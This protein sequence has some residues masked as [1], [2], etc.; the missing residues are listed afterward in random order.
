MMDIVRPK[1]LTCLG[2]WERVGDPGD[3]ARGSHCVREGS[4]FGGR[5]SWE[6]FPFCGGSHSRRTSKR[7]PFGGDPLGRASHKRGGGGGGGD[8]KKGLVGGGGGGAE[9][10]IKRVKEDEGFRAGVWHESMVASG[11]GRGV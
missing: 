5:S 4:P 11:R 10:K 3:K 9:G 6:G 7:V 1:N 8:S 2:E